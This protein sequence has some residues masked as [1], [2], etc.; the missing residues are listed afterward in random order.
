MVNLD[1]ES[2]VTLEEA[3]ALV[4]GMPFPAANVGEKVSQFNFWFE[5]TESGWVPT[6]TPQS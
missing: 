5:L 2:Q 4:N 3:T 1:E 6:D